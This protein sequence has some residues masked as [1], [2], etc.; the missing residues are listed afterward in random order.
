MK[1]HRS[2][3]LIIFLKAEHC[4]D[5][6]SA[7]VIGKQINDFPKSIL[8]LLSFFGTWCTFAS[9]WITWFGH[10]LSRD[11]L[12]YTY[13][14]TDA[15]YLTLI[16][17]LFS[18]GFWYFILKFSFFLSKCSFSLSLPLPITYKQVFSKDLPLAS[19]YLY[20]FIIISGLLILCLYKTQSSIPSPDVSMEG[21]PFVKLTSLRMI[22]IQ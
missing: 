10:S 11:T 6:T 19:F 2:L 1:A 4:H 21:P 9:I 7:S 18:P 14:A 5:F 17:T 12:N 8:L 13:K 16:D 20:D 15:M 3:S 22:C